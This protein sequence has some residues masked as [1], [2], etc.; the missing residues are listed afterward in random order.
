MTVTSAWQFTDGIQVIKT[1]KVH[2]HVHD[3]DVPTAIIQLDLPLIFSNG[4]LIKL[5]CYS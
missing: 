1:S 5:Y 2:A 3:N 4:V